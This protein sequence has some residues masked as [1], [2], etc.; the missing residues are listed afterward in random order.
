MPDVIW[1]AWIMLATITKTFLHVDFYFDELLEHLDSKHSCKEC[2]SNSW[3]VQSMQGAWVYIDSSFM[4][5]Q[6]WLG[7]II[8]FYFL[9]YFLNEAAGNLLVYVL[10]EKV[11]K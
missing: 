9:H 10:I 11:K 6:E 5:I 2:M 3:I 7:S 1:S 8:W 4:Q